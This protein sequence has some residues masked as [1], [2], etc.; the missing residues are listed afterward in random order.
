MAGRGRLTEVTIE[1]DNEPLGPGPSGARVKV[2]DY[3]G[4]RDCFYEPVNLDDPAILMQAGLRPSEA[5]PRFHQQMVYAVTLKVLENF[6]RALGRRITFRGKPLL[7][8]PHAFRDANAFFDPTLNAVCF[9]YF[10][11]DPDHPG[12]N[13]PGQTVFT[14]LSQDIIA[15]EV[16]HAVVHRLRKHF[17][18]PSNEDVLAF[19]EGFAD[20]VAIFQHF[21]FPDVLSE[22]IAST[23]G[24]LHSNSTLV[25]LAAQFGHATGK[26]DAL[27]TALDAPDPLLYGRATEPHERGSILV[28]AVFDG[29][30]AN[31]QHRIRDLIRIASEGS[32]ILPIGDLHPDLVDRLAREAAGAAQDV[33]TMCIRAF[34]YLPPVDVTFGDYLRALITADYDLVADD[35]VEQ[36][37]AMIEAFRRRGI[38]PEG[39]ISLSE[40]SLR[41]PAAAVSKFIPAQALAERLVSDA[42]AFDGNSPRAG[43][44]IGNEE[45]YR[46]LRS[47]AKQSA[48]ELGLDPKDR[49]HVHGFHATYRVNSSGQLVVEV[50]A[51][52]MQKRDT[53]K[54]ERFGGIPFRGGATVVASAD[55]RVR[56]VITKRMSD[57]RMERQVDFVS[58]LDLNDPWLPWGGE[59]YMRSR[60]RRDFRSLHRGI[61]A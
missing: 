4:T 36:R 24:Q 9:G 14:C 18:D 45:I 54:D 10:T 53:S 50:V 27:R 23:R 41:W 35:G 52:F 47:W 57:E 17:L 15:H 8:L 21:T 20:I 48:P 34:E 25:S 30:F 22:A 44:P 60:A 19:H 3:D 38:F 46:R 39:V 26:G 13:L 42:R 49:V 12:E 2:V 1:V 56:F 6:D 11:A 58:R 61:V 29:F 31:Y 28:A 59:R 5:D 7:L 40:S 16:T 32:G 37:R 55:G 51:Q 33:L 43:G